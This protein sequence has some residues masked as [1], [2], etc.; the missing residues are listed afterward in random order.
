[1]FKKLPNIKLGAI[2]FQ[3]LREMSA[4]RVRRGEQKQ[5]LRGRQQRR[6]LII[7]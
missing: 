1:M 6:N 2:D 7:I 3:T 5:S 4:L